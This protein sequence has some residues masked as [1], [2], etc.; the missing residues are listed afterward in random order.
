MF[1]AIEIT[2]SD[3]F[4]S[5]FLEQRARAPRGRQA[6]PAR[7]PAVAGFDGSPF[8]VLDVRRLHIFFRAVDPDVFAGE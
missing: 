8:P 5:E 3:L 6:P 1:D 7:R 2:S 4:S